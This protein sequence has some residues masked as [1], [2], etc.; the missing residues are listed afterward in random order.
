ML[1]NLI[2]FDDLRIALYMELHLP[3][4]MATPV[5]VCGLRMCLDNVEFDF[6]TDPSEW[7]N[8]ELVFLV[9]PTTETFFMK[10]K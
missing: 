3:Y 7:D 6:A 10:G 9:G 1:C 5:T 4:L 2:G 8:V